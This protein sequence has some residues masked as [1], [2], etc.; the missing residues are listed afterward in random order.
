MGESPMGDSPT[1]LGGTMGT[2]NWVTTLLLVN[3][4]K[5]VWP[6]ISIV[7]GPARINLN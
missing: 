1:C 2:V 6:E 7:F 4:E 3:L 5:L